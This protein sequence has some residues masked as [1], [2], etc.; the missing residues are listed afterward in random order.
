MRKEERGMGNNE[1]VA[2]SKKLVNINEKLGKVGVKLGKRVLKFLYDRVANF[3]FNKCD[4][5]IQKH[6]RFCCIF[7][8]R[9]KFCII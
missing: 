4:F 2:G 7:S 1:Q 9:C 6:L 5:V 8:V 3:K